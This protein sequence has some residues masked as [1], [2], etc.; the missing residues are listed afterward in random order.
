[1]YLQNIRIFSNNQIILR[2]K[3]AKYFL[4]FSHL[5]NFLP[6]ECEQVRERGRERGNSLTVF[7]GTLLA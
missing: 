5:S 1:M 3:Q 2:I 7:A 6:F 4:R